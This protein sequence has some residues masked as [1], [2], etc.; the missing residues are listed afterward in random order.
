MTD[1]F[2]SYTRKDQPWAE[3]IAWQLD[4]AGFTTLIQAWDF[5]SGGV[6]TIDM[7][8]R[9]GAVLTCDRRAVAGLPGFGLLQH[10]VAC[11]I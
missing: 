8:H 3:W 10:R 2:V 5:K 1:F 7:H 4:T 11:G 9:A 6:F